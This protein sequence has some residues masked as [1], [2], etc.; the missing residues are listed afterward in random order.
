M[1][2]S[3]V[4]RVM[5]EGHVPGLT[6]PSCATTGCSTRP[7]SASPT[8]PSGGPSTPPTQHLW[9]SM[10]KIA[11]ATAAVG[12][13]ERGR[14]RPRRA[15][16]AVRGRLPGRPGRR[17]THRRPAPEPHRRRRQPGSRPVGAA[18]QRAGARPDASSSLG[19]CGATVDPSTPVGGDAHYSNLGFL[20]L[21]QAM[22]VAA[23]RPFEEIV[24]DTVLGPAGMAATGYRW[25]PGA[26]A[27]TGYV[28]M[29]RAARPGPAGGPAGRHRRRAPGRRPAGVP[30]RSWST[31]RGM[32]ASWAT[33]STP[34]GSPRSTSATAARRGAG[35]LSPEAARRM[36]TIATP[37]KP[38]DLGL[39]WFRP[40]VT[41]GRV[42]GLRRAPR[43]GRR[44]LQRAA[45]LPRA[46][47]G[48]A[49][50]ANTTRPYDHHAICT[51]AIATD[52]S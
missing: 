10:S 40:A 34:V 27:A 11:T 22:A 13:A 31:A 7:A 20:L 30:C 16:P 52:W 36:R 1:L 8:W 49:I 12:M 33:S 47:L 43:L 18:G 42:A 25:R 3:T 44:L 4:E 28:R 32:A 45:H 15:D 35:V 41:G 14:A 23:E 50:M 5:A 9:F 21:A 51:A 19:G 6:S 17:R 29:P 38:F 48:V 2:A 26:P 37:G 39:G 46:D 24:T